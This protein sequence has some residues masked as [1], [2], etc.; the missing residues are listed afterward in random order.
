MD[1][2]HWQ[3]AV[4]IIP[5]N[6]VIDAQEHRPQPNRYEMIGRWFWRDKQDSV[7][8]RSVTAA[9]FLKEAVPVWK[10]KPARFSFWR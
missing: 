1:G 7:V 3:R 2:R 9:H 6:R 5:T 8:P 4:Q 10:P